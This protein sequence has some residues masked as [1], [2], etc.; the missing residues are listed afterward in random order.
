MNTKEISRSFLP[1]PRDRTRIDKS[2]SVIGVFGNPPS[3][4]HNPVEVKDV[5]LGAN[6]AAFIVTYDKRGVKFALDFPG[7]IVSEPE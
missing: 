3:N 7:L 4:P 1:S 2:W 5:E 6:N